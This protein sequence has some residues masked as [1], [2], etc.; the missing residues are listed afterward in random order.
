MKT[1]NVI[2]SSSQDNVGVGYLHHFVKCGDNIKIEHHPDHVLGG[3]SV[4][5]QEGKRWFG[6]DLVM[7][8]SGDFLYIND[9]GEWMSHGECEVVD[10][11]TFKL[12]R[13]EED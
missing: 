1:F 3:F 6:H 13:G 2:M 7:F 8:P 10:P 9:D 5:D 12:A 4:T 11:N